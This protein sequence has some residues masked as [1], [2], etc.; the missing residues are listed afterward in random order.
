MSEEKRVY[1][2]SAICVAS[3][4]VMTT[5]LEVSPKP[6]DVPYI[7]AVICS[8]L[9]AAVIFVVGTKFME[10]ERKLATV[11]ERI[12]FHA[13]LLRLVIQQ[14]PEAVMAG[15]GSKAQDLLDLFAEEETWQSA[16]NQ[17]LD[18]DRSK[19]LANTRHM[20]GEQ[21]A[22]MK[23]LVETAIDAGLQLPEGWKYADLA[24][25]AKKSDSAET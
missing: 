18:S 22:Y 24:T 3:P 20:I 8:F 16:Y 2:L 1:W 15:L 17:A 4:V 7:V 9:F 14:N 11:T 23:K 19:E 21:K 25:K 13:W 12:R 10:A 6:Y 5:V